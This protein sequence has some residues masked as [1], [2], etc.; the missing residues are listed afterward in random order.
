MTAADDDLR[1]LAVAL[2]DLSR[3]VRQA[4]STQDGPPRLPPTEFEVMRYVAAQPGTSVGGAAA[5][6][7]L[8][9][10][11]V[12]AA[13]RGLVARGLVERTADPSDARVARLRPTELAERY[14]DPVEAGWARTLAAA[15]AHLAPA[16][17]EA[18][19]RAAG[20]LA[21]LA[22]HTRAPAAAPGTGGD[23]GGGDGGAPGPVR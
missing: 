22:G 16:D 10:S 4:Q 2:H 17:A 1:R 14:K 23:D 12:S 13:V 11:N 9:Q 7:D 3:A 21:R 20:P 6:L 19:R 18:V 8:R 15:L 5:A